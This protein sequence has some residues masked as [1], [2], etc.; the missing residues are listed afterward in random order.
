MVSCRI[1]IHFEL[2]KIS[3]PEKKAKK[4][5]KAV[6]EN[7]TIFTEKHLC[8][9]LFLIK[10]QT[11]NSIKKRLTQVFSCEYWEILKNAYFEKHLFLQRLLLATTLWSFESF[12]K[13]CYSSKLSFGKECFYSNLII[14]VILVLENFNIV[15][16]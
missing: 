13:T 15:W 8:L 3:L 7:F 14:F 12:E 11:C 2:P 16:S 5:K 10:L 9:S 1:S 6:L 4:L